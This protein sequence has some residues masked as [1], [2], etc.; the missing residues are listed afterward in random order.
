MS[1]PLKERSPRH[2]LKQQLAGIS[3]ASASR[4]GGSENVRVL[5]IIVAE[6]ELGNIERH[7][8]AAY[9][10]ERAD[11]TALEDRPEAP[12]VFV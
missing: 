7:V 12:I 5:P 1:M 11:N 3:F 4:D 10:V 9:F 8:F 6:L 2:R